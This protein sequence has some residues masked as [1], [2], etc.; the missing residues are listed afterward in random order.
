MRSPAELFEELRKLHAE[1]V[2]VE[3]GNLLFFQLAVGFP[4]TAIGV[5]LDPDGLSVLEGAMEAGGIPVGY[6]FAVRQGQVLVFKWNPLDDFRDDQ[7]TLENANRF[8]S[9]IAEAAASELQRI[10]A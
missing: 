4:E 8:L 10:R 7:D 3:G 2:E 5:A 1:T 9:A 6:I